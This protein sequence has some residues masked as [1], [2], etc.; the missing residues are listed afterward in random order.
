VSAK[1]QQWKDRIVA[2]HLSRIEHMF[3]PE[4]PKI[5]LLVRTPWLKDG[6]IL[7]TNDST[8]AAL[9]EFNRLREKEEVR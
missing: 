8:D 6:G 2:E 1:M 4:C 7:I 9:A 3:A 5:T